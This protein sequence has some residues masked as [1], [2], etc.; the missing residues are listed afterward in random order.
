MDKGTQIS[1]STESNEG[2]YALLLPLI[3]LRVRAIVILSM[4]YGLCFDDWRQMLGGYTENSWRQMVV[5]PMSANK[6]IVGERRSYGYIYR[7]TGR[8]R[9]YVASE[10]ARIQGEGVILVQGALSCSN[11]RKDALSVLAGYFPGADQK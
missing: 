2:S 7:V 4:T 10:L 1:E 8:G 9:A 3:P 5:K 11:V 6:L